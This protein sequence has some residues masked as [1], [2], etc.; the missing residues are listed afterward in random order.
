VRRRGGAR[1]GQRY[2]FRRND[3]LQNQAVLMVQEGL[4]GPPRVLIDP[5]AWSADGTVAL[6]EAYPSPDGRFVAYTIQDGGSDWRRARILDVTSGEV[7]GDT[8]DW[9][10]F[11][12]IA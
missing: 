5:N 1:A 4:E 11:T 6:A 9:L 12:S 8:L 10:K 2:F 7:L 3:G